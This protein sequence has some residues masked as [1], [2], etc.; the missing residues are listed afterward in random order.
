M[1]DFMK[2]SKVN[3]QVNLG[4]P[5]VFPGEAINVTVNFQA[6]KE[7]K[8]EEGRV[9][10]FC[11]EEYKVEERDTDSDGSTTTTTR[12]KRDDTEFARHVFLNQTTLAAGAMQTV[13][14]NPT[15]TPNALPTWAGGQ[16]LRINWF[17]KASIG[18]KMALDWN[19]EKEL[20]VLI[21]PPGKFNHPA[22]FGSSNKPAEIELAFAL[23]RREWVV[24]ETIEGEL[25]VNPKKDIDLNEIKLELNHSEHVNGEGDTKVK[26]QSVKLLGKTKLTSGQTLRYPFKAAI[27]S[28]RPSTGTAQH[29][30][31]KWNLSASLTRGFLKGSYDVEMEIFVYS[32]R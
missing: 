24:G 3:L 10:L 12:W 32:Q 22:E 31:V 9:V 26:E 11:R 18:R 5:S 8:V 20:I 25:L 28:P 6:E 16:S 7:I 27:P 2:G 23:P 19:A 15:L 4:R 21:P 13:E 1:F 17:V 14:F 29:G 30:E